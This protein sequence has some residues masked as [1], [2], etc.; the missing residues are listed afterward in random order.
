[1]AQRIHA[2]TIEV[3]SSHVSFI[4]HPNEVAQ[5]IKEAATAN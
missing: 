5:L 3:N 2:K 1:M 4:S